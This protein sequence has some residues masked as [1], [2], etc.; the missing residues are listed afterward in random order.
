[1]K[2]SNFFRILTFSGLILSSYLTYLT[3][4]AASCPLY[5][6][7]DL[8]ITSQYSKISGIPVAFFG[9]LGFLLLLLSFEMKK[10]NILLASGILGVIFVTY[11]QYVQIFLINQTCLYC[12]L[13]HVLYISSFLIAYYTLKNG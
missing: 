12:T 5:G 10:N 6:D 4:T 8:V 3:Y 11:L 1:M 13:T 9:I 2:T 7:C